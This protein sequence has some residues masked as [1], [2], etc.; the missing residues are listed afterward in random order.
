MKITAVRTV[1]LTG[2]STNDPFL[3]EARQLRSA[4]LV[5]VEG[6]DG[7][8][9][10]G[11]TYAGYFC[12][13]LVPAAVDFFAPIV[14]GQGLDLDAGDESIR[15]AIHQLWQRM[16][17]CG[18]YWCRVGF[19]AAVLS[20]VEAALWDLAG[21]VLG[22]PVYELLGGAH[23]PKLP[24]YATGGPSNYPPERLAEKADYY[25]NLGFQGLK[26]GTGAWVAGEGWY[27]PRGLQ[28]TV[29]FE[30]EKIERLRHQVGPLIRILVDGHMGNSPAG[31][32]DLNTAQAVLKALEPFDIFLFEEPLPYTD[33]D[34]YAAL[35]KSTA[36]PVAGGECLSAPC[37][38]QPYVSRRAF[39]IGQPDASWVGGLGPFLEIARLFDAD[40]K[41]IATHAWGAGASLMQN[42]HA[43]FAAPNTCIL[44]VPPAYGPLHSELIGDSFVMEDGFVLPP[45]TPGLGIV[46]SERVKKK[47]PFIPGS[48]E[49][50]SVPGKVL[51]D[52][53][54]RS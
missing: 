12:P 16:Y 27:E 32:W 47:Y 39:D 35:V 54:R 49:F 42:I 4:A 3:A 11:E 10:V 43:G 51:N 26:I 20:G 22:K 30:R 36:A 33:P 13:E 29:Q 28:E 19:G 18:N 40:Q 53:L 25:L 24:C 31:V 41:S 48:G 46:L 45:Q 7:T 52:Q 44:E 8:V 14:I 23:E 2:P 50:N 5:E 1:L 38:W 6:E 9:G 34:A 15:G 17:R 37:E 21:K